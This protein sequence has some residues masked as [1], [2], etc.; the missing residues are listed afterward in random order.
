M[1]DIPKALEEK[2]E[3]ASTIFEQHDKFRIITHYDADGIASAS[4]LA[5]SLMKDHKGFHASFVDTLPDNFTEEI[6][7]IFTDIGNSYLE[8]ITKI[9]TPVIVLDHH[10]VRKNKDNSDTLKEDKVF[11]NPHDHG[12]D[13][14]QEISGSTLSLLFTVFHDENNWEDSLYGLAGAAADKQAL[15]GFTGMN[16]KIV[17]KAEDKGY[18]EKRKGLFIDGENVKDALVNACDPYFPS[19]S[20]DEETVKEILEGLDIDPE[21]KITSLSKDKSRKLTSLL[22]L[23]LLK[24]KVSLTVIE[25]IYGNRYQC[26]G[27]NINIDILYKILNSCARENKPGLGLALCLGDEDSLEEAKSIRSKYRKEMVGKLS[28]LKEDVVELDN[29]QYFFEEKKT[30]KGELAGLGMLYF[31]PQDK[32]VLALTEQEDE[33][34]ISVRASEQ[35]VNIGLDLGQICAELTEEIGGQGGGHDIAAGATIGKEDLDDFLDMIDDEVGK[36]L[37]N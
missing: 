11:V 3:R 23:T 25:S 12:I 22:V 15:N 8:K 5:R 16:K 10:E 36:I 7:I 35:M 32:P 33:I 19:I 17:E 37:T 13:G 20:G 21:S 30:R 14:A 26:E 9:D 2:L 31:L 18:L 24:R 29:I 27:G 28:S 4:V 1:F 34:D 6:P